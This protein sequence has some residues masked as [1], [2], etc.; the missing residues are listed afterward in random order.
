MITLCFQL[1]CI[2]C[3]IMK[4]LF[5]SFQPTAVARKIA[6]VSANI[7]PRNSKTVIVPDLKCFIFPNFS[8]IISICMNSFILYLV[9]ISWLVEFSLA[10]NVYKRISWEIEIYHYNKLS[11]FNQTS[12]SIIYIFITSIYLYI[13]NETQCVVN[14]S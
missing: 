12:Q 2:C 5:N 1:D 7:C 14:F 11:R 3:S 9:G 8:S 6:Y 4:M 10:S 13:L